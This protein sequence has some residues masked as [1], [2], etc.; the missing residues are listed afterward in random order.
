MADK[1]YIEREAVLNNADIITVHTREYGSIDVIPVDC[2]SDIPS[3]DVVEV[4]RCKDCKHWREAGTGWRGIHYG[5][6]HNI[7]ND[8]FPFHTE[9]EPIT[10]DKDYC[11]YG[12]RKEQT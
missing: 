2:V 9:H 4:V 12:E 3:A 7:H 8:G 5:Y 1:E 6:C 11:S 10:K